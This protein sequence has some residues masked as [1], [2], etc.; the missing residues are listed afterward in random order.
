MC[1][2]GISWA[3]AVCQ[4]PGSWR[5]GREKV[6]P[7]PCHNLAVTYIALRDEYDTFGNRARKTLTHSAIHPTKARETLASHWCNC[8]GATRKSL[9]H[10]GG[11]VRADA[12]PNSESTVTSKHHVLRL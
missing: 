2:I 12:E 4:H 9:A 5:A 7:K 3:Y 8:A 1:K 11:T 10:V 6:E